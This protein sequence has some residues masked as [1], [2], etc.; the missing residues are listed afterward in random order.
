MNSPNSSRFPFLIIIIPPFLTFLQKENVSQSP[1]SKI[2]PTR[3]HVPQCSAQFKILLLV[4]HFFFSLAFFLFFSL[5]K[6]K[7]KTAKIRPRSLPWQGSAHRGFLSGRYR[8]ATATLRGRKTSS[9]LGNFG[10]T[11][12][13]TIVCKVWKVFFSR[14]K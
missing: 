2:K 6:S 7:T 11:E 14:E 3:V 1:P 12:V 4:G 13:K 8:G 5:L 10:K 9:T